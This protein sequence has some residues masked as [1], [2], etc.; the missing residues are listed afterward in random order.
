[1]PLLRPRGT[2]DP[3]GKGRI[4]KRQLRRLLL[5]HCPQAERTQASGQMECGRGRQMAVGMR[6]DEIGD[7]LDSTV[8]RILKIWD[9]CASFSLFAP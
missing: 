1:M 7:G 8:P 6:W 9:V 5:E 4:E 3:D 2:Y